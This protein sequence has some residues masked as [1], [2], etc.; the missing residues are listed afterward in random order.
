MDLREYIRLILTAGAKIDRAT[1]EEIGVLSAQAAVTGAFVVAAERRFEETPSRADIA[2]L[3]SR[4]RENHV[5]R[6][7]LPPML[8]EA[9]LRIAFGEESLAEGMS[10]EEMTTGQ[11]MLAYGMVHDLGLRDQ[12]FEDFLTEAAQAAQEIVAEE[13]S[14]S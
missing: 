4:I 11:L 6:D 9:L 7:R 10:D 12:D 3:V 8:G 2:A 13:S 5:D 14:S 1:V